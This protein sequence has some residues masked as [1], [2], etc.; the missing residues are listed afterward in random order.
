M[1]SLFRRTVQ[2]P[3]PPRDVTRSPF[4]P[5]APAT[6]RNTLL[7]AE[8]RRDG[9]RVAGQSYTVP[10]GKI[11]TAEGGKIKKRIKCASVFGGGGIASHQPSAEFQQLDRP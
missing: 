10:S 5:G 3:P 4:S 11:K 8:D 1:R 7:V 9:Y 2:A 6:V